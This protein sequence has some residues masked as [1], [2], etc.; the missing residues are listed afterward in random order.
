MLLEPGHRPA[1]VGVEVALLLGKSLIKCLVDKRQC[2]SNGQRFTF[3]VEY[4]RVPRINSHA[5]TDRRLSEIHGCDVAAL[6]IGESLWKFGLEP[7][8]E[9]AAGGGRRRR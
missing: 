8:E 9:L 1:A 5:G 4:L 7:R 2:V 6:K 3:C